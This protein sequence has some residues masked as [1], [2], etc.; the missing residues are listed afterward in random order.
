M[1][2]REKTAKIKIQRILHYHSHS[3]IK[4]DLRRCVSVP[5]DHSYAMLQCLEVWAKVLFKHICDRKRPIYRAIW[6]KLVSFIAA[7][8]L[9]NVLHRLVSFPICSITFFHSFPVNTHCCTNIFAFK[10]SERTRRGKFALQ[11]ESNWLLC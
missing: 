2:K 1:C 5:L 7:G 9:S 8:V 4:G 3:Q 6:E 10:C 11:P